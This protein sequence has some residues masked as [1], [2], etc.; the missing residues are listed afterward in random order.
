[1]CIDTL[2]NKCKICF[3]CAYKLVLKE[4]HI[5]LH[6]DLD[7]SLKHYKTN[8]SRIECNLPHYLTTQGNFINIDD[9]IVN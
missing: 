6:D 5:F 4:G 3:S 2:Y 9:V 7:K 8:L 1:M